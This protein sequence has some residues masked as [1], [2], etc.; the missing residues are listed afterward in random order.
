MRS[1]KR[2]GIIGLLFATLLLST[3]FNPVLTPLFAEESQ[4]FKE[5]GHTVSGKFLDYWRNN[6][7][8]PTY[9]YPITEAQMETDPETGKQFLTQWFERHRLELH[10]ENAG[11]KYEVLAGLLGKDLRREALVVDPDFLKAEVLFN[12]AYSKDA[13]WYFPETGHNLRF[14]FLDY[15][16]KNGGLERFGYPISEEHREIDP[17][18][19]QIFVMQWFERARFEYHPENLGTPYDVL[20]GLLGN[21][22]KSPKSKFEFMWKKGTSYRDI[23]GARS[24]TTDTNGNVYVADAGNYQIVKFDRDGRLITKWGYKGNGDGQFTNVTKVVAS[25]ENLIFTLDPGDFSTTTKPRIQKFS[26]DGKFLGSINAYG[27]NYSDFTRSS[28]IAISQDGIL[29]RLDVNH[30][31][32]ASRIM[33]ISPNGIYL[34]G[35]DRTG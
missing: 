24:I 31:Y 30:D 21:Q 23:K 9:G 8:L 22:L 32:T 20:L 15:W 12:T 2:Q 29:Y 26:A 3:L 11:T 28:N 27:G 16:Q 4:Y 17:E 1:G 25:P 6:G 10:P 35:M 13:Q 7:G 5:T 18:T 19:G 34:G 14:R 33:K